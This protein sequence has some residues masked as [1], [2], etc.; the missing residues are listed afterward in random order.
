M[1]AEAEQDFSDLLTTLFVD[2]S[3]IAIWFLAGTAAAAAGINAGLASAPIW[4]VV[5][6]G[7][8]ASV[9]VG[10][11]L[12]AV[13]NA[14]GITDKVR[15]LTNKLESSIEDFAES[16]MERIESAKEF[17]KEGFETTKEFM[18]NANPDDGK[19]TGPNDL[20]VEIGASIEHYYDSL[21]W[22]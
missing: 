4:A 22:P 1:V 13:D 20:I 7:I 16:M 8:G 9:V 11:I 3:K 2:I 21:K 17:M 12:D 19:I 18:T 15:A 14:W 10:M 6:A 5:A